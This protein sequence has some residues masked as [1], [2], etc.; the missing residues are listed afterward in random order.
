[1]RG[2]SGSNT[3]VINSHQNSRYA[4]ASGAQP[5]APA[6]SSSTA[7]LPNRTSSTCPTNSNTPNAQPLPS[8]GVS[9]F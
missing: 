5:N 7:I 3:A 6:V 4:K 9:H 2:V 1:M 8:L